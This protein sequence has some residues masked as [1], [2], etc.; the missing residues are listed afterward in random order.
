MVR[1]LLLLVALALPLTGVPLVL[2][3]QAAGSCGDGDAC[4]C[5]PEPEEAGAS[6]CSEKEAPK[7]FVAPSCGC[8]GDHG[9][10]HLVLDGDGTKVPPPAE[11]EIRHAELASLPTPAAR[12]A[13]GLGRFA[14][15]LRPP[16]A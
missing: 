4:C 7:V 2:Q 10:G 13:D 6:C 3:N 16:R 12:S 15:E 1:F 14:P 8:G 5:L 11:G 9:P